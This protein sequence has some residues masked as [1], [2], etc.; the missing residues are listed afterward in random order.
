MYLSC[1][2]ICVWFIVDHTQTSHNNCFSSTI[3]IMKYTFML[4]LLH[5]LQDSLQ[6][7]PQ[8]C[9]VFWTLSFQAF[10][11][12]LMI[13]Y[14]TTHIEHWGQ[15]PTV[16]K[17]LWPWQAPPWYK[18]LAEQ[19]IIIVILNSQP[20]CLRACI[21][22]QATVHG[23]W[24]VQRYFKGEGALNNVVMVMTDVFWTN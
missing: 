2:V 11:E 4:K 15:I 1:H 5:Y 6:T 14:S 12:W 24:S 23:A 9:E 8:P 13:C 3:I 16:C 7:L 17:E 10:K 20:A 19:T 21:A 18:G 22:V